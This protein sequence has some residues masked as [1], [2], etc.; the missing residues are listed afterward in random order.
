MHQSPFKK[1][2]KF[3]IT[4]FGCGCQLP[5]AIQLG[6]PC[7]QWPCQLKSAVQITGGV[8]ASRIDQQPPGEHGWTAGS[9]HTSIRT[10]RIQYGGDLQPLRLESQIYSSATSKNCMWSQKQSHVLLGQFRIYDD[11]TRVC[12]NKSKTVF[13]RFI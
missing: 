6:Q 5:L 4:S 13:M 8:I 11:R 12:R 9:D 1:D 7:S 2:A 3:E 10:Q